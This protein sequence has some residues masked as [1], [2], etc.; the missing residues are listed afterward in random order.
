MSN[1][2]LLK[3]FGDC[4]RYFLV[5]DF[6]PHLLNF[7]VL[8]LANLVAFFQIAGMLQNH[9]FDFFELGLD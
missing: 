9:S 1:W 8:V 5:F 7:V 3:H 4:F 2:K 6:I